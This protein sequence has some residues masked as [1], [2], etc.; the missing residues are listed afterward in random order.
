MFISYFITH[1]KS[2]F[3]PSID[4]KHNVPDQYD[5]VNVVHSCSAAIP[6][7]WFK[8]RGRFFCVILAPNEKANGGMRLPTNFFF[9]ISAEGLIWGSRV[10]AVINTNSSQQT[11]LELIILAVSD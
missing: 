2:P 3:I 4:V 7:V 1:H 10:N 9:E 6:M 5:V 8:S 11:K